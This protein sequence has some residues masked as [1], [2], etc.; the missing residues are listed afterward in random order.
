M[1]CKIMKILW[2][3]RHDKY[4]TNRASIH[5]LYWRAQDVHGHT[6][7]LLGRRDSLF[8]WR[9]YKKIKQFKPDV[10]FVGNFV[11]FWAVWLRMLGLIQ[12]P[13]V[14]C[15]NEILREA[16]PWADIPKWQYVLIKPF[17]RRIEIF[18]A[19]HSDASIV[20]GLQNAVL[21]R[22]YGAEN[23]SFFLNAYADNT[24]ESS[25]H[26]NSDKFKVAYLG[27]QS[28]WNRKNIGI[29][30]DAVEDEN[31]EL[32]MIGKIHEPTKE[33]APANVQFVGEVPANEVNSVLS[34]ADCL[35]N[36][37]DQDACAKNGEYVRAGKPLLVY[38]G[39]GMQENIFTHNYNAFITDDVKAGLLEI[40]NNDELRDILSSNIKKMPIMDFNERADKM[41]IIIHDI[42]KE[43]ISK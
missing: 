12:L 16:S 26:L 1:G 42:Y 43:H 17:L 33:K 14:N 34:E 15:W 20:S 27:D 31:C 40:I 37:T 18:N 22:E 2:A 8:P 11:T 35:I 13:I 38:R 5:R 10:L 7:D 3:T 24:K 41:L 6:C 23:I 9:L 28:G 25:I 36:C 29:M 30:F 39:R 21:G 4:D 32:F 19:I